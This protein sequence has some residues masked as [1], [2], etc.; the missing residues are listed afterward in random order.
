M[1]KSVAVLTDAT[2]A[3]FWFPKW[4][5]YYGK[6]F[7]GRNLYVVTYEGKRRAFDGFELGGVWDVPQIYSES[8]R[9]QI[10]AA[11]IDTL[12][13]THKVVLRCDVDEFLVPDLRRYGSLRDYLDRL[14]RPY[15]TAFGIDVFESRDD[16]PLDM[17]RP[18]IHAQRS[19]GVVNSALHKTAV[20]QVPIKW[21]AGFHAANVP[22]AFNDLYML[23]TKFAD[24]QSRATWFHF[25]KSRLPEGSSEHKYFS[26][27]E[28]QF[29]Q[30]KAWLIQ[31]RCREDGWS[32]ISGPQASA[33]FLS[34]VSISST[35]IQQG[36]FVTGDESF[37]LPKEFRGSF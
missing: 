4:H 33:Q 22:P 13:L 34:S 30:H 36:Q 25:M 37:V 12:L 24:V 11:L 9:V 19:Q 17:G 1:S 29:K 26:F 15:V 16:Q 32:A 3:D 7:G 23:H 28:E 21:A 2:S 5:E 27:T 18:I 10:V 31:K 6:I 35:G 20:T 14:E 8:E